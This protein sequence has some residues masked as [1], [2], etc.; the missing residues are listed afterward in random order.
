MIIKKKVVGA[1]RQPCTR[2][3]FVRIHVKL[4]VST[5]TRIAGILIPFSARGSCNWDNKTGILSFAARLNS[6]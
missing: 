6:C 2:G 1:Q 3:Q 4:F 5:P